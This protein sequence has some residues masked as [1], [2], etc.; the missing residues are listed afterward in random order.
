MDTLDNRILPESRDLFKRA[1]WTDWSGS[2]ARALAV[3][4]MVEYDW[5][6]QFHRPSNKASFVLLFILIC[7]LFAE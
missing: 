6:N 1:T 7:D 2:G 3:A 4:S 5:I